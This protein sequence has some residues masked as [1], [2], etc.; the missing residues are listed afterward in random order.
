M[1]LS[2]HPWREKAFP[3][4]PWIF[5]HFYQMLWRVRLT[6]MYVL[7]SKKSPCC[8]YCYPQLWCWLQRYGREGDAEE[9][10]EG[11]EDALPEQRWQAPG[12]GFKLALTGAG[13]K[14]R[15]ANRCGFL[16]FFPFLLTRFDPNS[17][18]VFRTVS[19]NFSKIWIALEKT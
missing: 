19:V 9:W 17:F 5:K 15:L 13:G 12:T 11:I 6:S 2:K 8:V 14:G 1:V 16:S 7:T 18:V 4:Y 3:S 10:K